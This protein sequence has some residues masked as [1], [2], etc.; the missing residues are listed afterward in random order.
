MTWFRCQNGNG[1]GSGGNY[2]DTAWNGSL[3]PDTRIDTLTGLEVSTSGYGATDFIY[4]GDST[5]LYR[6]GDIAQAGYNAFYDSNKTYITGFYGG[7]DTTIP[8]NAKYAR[9][10]DV[11]PMDGKIFTRAEGGASGSHDYSTVEHAVGTWIDSSTV[12]EK[13]LAIPS[14]SVGQNTIQHGISNF[15]KMIN[16]LATIRYDGDYLCMPYVST[17]ILQYGLGIS[18]FNST[19]YFIEVGQSFDVS[20]FSDGYVIIRYTKSSS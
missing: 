11:A 15:G 16:C 4:L 19:R 17:S 7:T 5:T 3:I 10:S 18:N 1:G 13:T 2:T 20:K 12:Y 14:L 6:C 9:L 8:S